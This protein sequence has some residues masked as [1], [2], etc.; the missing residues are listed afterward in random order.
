MRKVPRPFSYAWGT[1]QIVEE[2]TAPNGYYEPVIQLLRPEG[3]EHDGEE[4]VRFCFYS[5]GGAF[6]RHP[7]V[8]GPRDI[9]ALA[10][11]LKKTPRLRRLLKRLLRD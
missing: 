9:V 3:G 8:V 1:G 7:L 6:Q 5:V 10:R 4:H 11:M 2:A